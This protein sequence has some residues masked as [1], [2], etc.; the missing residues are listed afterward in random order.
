MEACDTLTIHWSDMRLLL[1]ALL[2][3]ILYGQDS[4]RA[5]ALQRLQQVLSSQNPVNWV[6]T[7]TNS[8]KA[9]EATRV[10]A[11]LTDVHADPG[12]CTLSFKDG[13]SLP[14]Q[15]FES[16]QTWTVAIPDIDRIQVDSMEGFLN[17]LRAEG[18]QPPWDTKTSPIVFVLQMTAARNRNFNEHRWS[19]NSNNEVVERD[20]HQSLAFVVFAA[21]AT[22]REA[23]GALQ[24]AK[25]YCK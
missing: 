6:Q 7:P 12:A 21:E 16:V 9:A 10:T 1:P 23:A 15:K 19:R 8:A 18:G 17:R 2:A 5:S 14:D 25:D 4:T 24:R 20:F 13:R 22:A 11:S 3:V